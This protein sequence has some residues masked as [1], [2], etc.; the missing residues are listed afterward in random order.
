MPSYKKLCARY[1]HVQLREWQI[2]PMHSRC[3]SC[4]YCGLVNYMTAGDPPPVTKWKR[5]V[6]LVAGIALTVCTVLGAALRLGT[7]RRHVLR[8]RLCNAQ[9]HR[10]ARRRDR[11][12][13]LRYLRGALPG[14]DALKSRPGVAC[15]TKSR[16][17]VKRRPLGLRAPPKVRLPPRTQLGVPVH[18]ESIASCGGLKPDV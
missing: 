1:R 13:R 10:A 14:Q 12:S 18:A 15:K 3:K 4:L 16:R 17:K 5:P 2:P 8:D 7:H 6:L 9:H 11:G